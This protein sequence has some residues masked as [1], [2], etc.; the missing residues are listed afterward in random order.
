MKDEQSAIDDI[1]QST[2]AKTRYWLQN[3]ILAVFNQI[4][5][6]LHYKMGEKSTPK[7]NQDS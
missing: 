7:K 5:A 3:G 4:K 6:N 1:T 2:N